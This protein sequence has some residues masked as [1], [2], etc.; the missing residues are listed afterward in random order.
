MIKPRDTG[1]VLPK[2]SNVTENTQRF[3]RYCGIFSTDIKQPVDLYN[4]FLKKY[5]EIKQIHLAT[6]LK[7]MIRGNLYFYHI[8]NTLFRIYT[9]MMESVLRTEYH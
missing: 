2:G 1:D 4:S 3:T 8:R 5:K 7:H 6:V 9:I